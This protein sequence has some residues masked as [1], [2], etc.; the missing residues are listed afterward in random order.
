MQRR[1]Y[2][3]SPDSKSTLRGCLH[4]FLLAIKINADLI[5]R[6][7]HNFTIGIVIG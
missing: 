7:D 1:S 3:C 5:I 2:A 4:R 6:F